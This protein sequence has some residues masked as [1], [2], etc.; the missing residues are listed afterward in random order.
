MGAT[1][2]GGPPANDS[3]RSSAFRSTMPWATM[4]PSSLHITACFM[5]PTGKVAKLLMTWLSNHWAA[6]G[7]EIVVG[8][9]RDSPAW[10]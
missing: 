8:P 10:M 4:R 9:V 5:L 6:P 7:P 1:R 2:P 3:K